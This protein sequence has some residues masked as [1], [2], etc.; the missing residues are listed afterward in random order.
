MAR[1]WQR[2]SF[3]AAERSQRSAV[4]KIKQAKQQVR[5]SQ[6]PHS[7]R[8]HD[9]T[10]SLSGFDPKRTQR[11]R[12]NSNK[13]LLHESCPA[14]ASPRQTDTPVS[15]PRR[16]HTS[17]NTSAGHTDREQ[18]AAAPLP[19]LSFYFKYIPNSFLHIIYMFYIYIYYLCNTQKTVYSTA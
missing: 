15:E 1:G 10:P 2:P 17:A 13:K 6:R 16:L 11:V 12:K 8:W 18:R 4:F 14:S 5:D 3:V 19:R 7:E 9:F